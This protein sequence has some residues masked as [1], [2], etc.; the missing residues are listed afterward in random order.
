[1]CYNLN[2]LYDLLFIEKGNNDLIIL[3]TLITLFE[4]LQ[5]KFAQDNLVLFSVYR[6]LKYSYCLR[7][8]L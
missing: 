3:L 5:K 8:E 1:M 4:S 6:F 7:A 2:C